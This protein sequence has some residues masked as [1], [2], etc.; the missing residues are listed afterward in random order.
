MWQWYLSCQAR[1]NSLPSSH[2][3]LVWYT[4]LVDVL[5]LGHELCLCCVSGEVRCF[6]TD[7]HLGL[8]LKCFMLLH[9]ILFRNKNYWICIYACLWFLNLPLCTSF[10]QT[11]QEK[12]VAHAAWMDRLAQQQ[13]RPEA[14]ART[15]DRLR[16][17]RSPRTKLIYGL[18]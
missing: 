5:S 2:V 13:I 11:S 6:N 14:I 17:G 3:C 18:W 10:C 9:K 15:V 7:G 12:A 1:R 16:C 8:T 4:G